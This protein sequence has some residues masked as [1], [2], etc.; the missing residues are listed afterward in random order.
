MMSNED[1]LDIMIALEDGATLASLARTYKCSD[2]AIRN[3][4]QGV[5]GMIDA[6]G[7]PMTVWC[8]ECGA[9]VVPPCV[10]CMTRRS[11]RL[12]RLPAA[13]PG[14]EDR[15]FCPSENEM[16]ATKAELRKR[17]LAA[18]RDEQWRDRE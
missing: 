12:G 17:R 13:E 4:K 16:E 11:V 3:I 10:A 7:V 2:Q 15:T 5:R 14:D 9:N 18:K 8:P 6:R 1:V